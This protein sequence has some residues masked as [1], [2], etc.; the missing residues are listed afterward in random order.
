[1]VLWDVTTA[2]ALGGSEDLVQA[3]SGSGKK[4]EMG[5]AG[6]VRDLAWVLSGPSVLA[7]LM[8][9]GLFLLWDPQGG[10][11]QHLA[12]FP[13]NQFAWNLEI[14]PCKHLGDK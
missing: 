12:W 1:M 13:C 2:T 14:G 6:A 3:A 7:V 11:L 10:S 4:S 9:S 8:A 5:R